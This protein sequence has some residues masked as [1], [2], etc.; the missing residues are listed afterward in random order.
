MTKTDY[1]LLAAL[2]LV[3]SILALTNLGSTS[4]PQTFW[5]KEDEESVMVD[6][7]REQQIRRIF[8]F[9]LFE[10]LTLSLL[11]SGDGR[12]WQPCK[13]DRIT[14]TWQWDYVGADV[15]ARYVR[16]DVD[17]K[18]ARIFEMAFFGDDQKVPIPIAQVTAVHSPPHPRTSA[19]SLFDEQTTAKYDPSYMDGMYFDEIY[20][21][22]TAW[23]HLHRIE[24]YESTHPPL[25]KLFISLGVALFGMTPF[26]WRIVGTLFGIG[27]IPLMYIFG[28]AL[29][30][31]TRYA[32]MTAFLMTFDFMHFS[33]TRIAT[34]DTYG[35]FFI[36]LMYYYMFR[37]Y[38]LSFFLTDLRKTLVPL[39]L[40]GLFFGL[41]AASKWI[42]IYAGVGLAVILA[43]CLTRRYREY[44]KGKRLLKSGWKKSTRQDTAYYRHVTQVFPGHLLKTLAWCVI[45]FVVI[46]GIIYVLSYI[47]FMMV[48]G[49]GHGLWNV[50]TYQQHILSYHKNLKATHPY[51]SPWWSWPLMLRPLWMYDGTD[52]IPKEMVSSIV[53]MGNPAIWWGGILAVIGALIMYV[54]K[55]DD[56]LLPILIGLGAQYI[57]W[58]LVPRL[59]FIYHFFAAIPFV[60]FC[61]V[62]CI[63][64]FEL[65][66]PVLRPVVYGYLL[67]VLILF[68]GFFPILSGMLVSKAYVK[69]F[70]KWFG[71]WYFYR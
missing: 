23:E 5:M 21:A 16:I 45:F 30:K 62:Y 44:A 4:A 25:G 68:A 54:E 63:R 64:Q 58:M 50:V 38:E 13:S 48:P 71:G 19:G 67:L 18:G 1:L 69:N 22:R 35:V 31:E 15:R 56:T 47:P 28:K 36:I 32:F 34:I 26:G 12:T 29:F 52:F 53:T 61:I 2:V 57:P 14:D 65:K 66:W 33:Q 51:S 43:I 42:C 49:P 46:P 39:G 20:H 7:G 8:Y 17:K 27:M 37:Y 6:F 55:E 59:T 70:L 11:V 41:G 24:P 3:Y 40:S 10:N 60:I 9:G